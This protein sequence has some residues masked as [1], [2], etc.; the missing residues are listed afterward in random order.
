MIS[1]FPRLS[2]KISKLVELAARLRREN[3]DLRLDLA[4][5]AAENAELSKR[6]Q[7]A[8]QRVSALLDKLPVQ[9]QDEEAA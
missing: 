4:A 2:D 6:M 5:L 8:H 9:E 1:D 3:A 7:E